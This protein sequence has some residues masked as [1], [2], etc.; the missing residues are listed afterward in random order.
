MYRCSDT[1]IL[2]T[3]CGISTRCEWKMKA[4]STLLQLTGSR[5]LTTFEE[6]STTG[7]RDAAQAEENLRLIRT[8]YD[9]CKK[10]AVIRR[11]KLVCI[12]RRAG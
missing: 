6:F 5:W 3:L 2:G 11:G 7:L 10:G 1:R 12:A 8:S 9:K 4:P